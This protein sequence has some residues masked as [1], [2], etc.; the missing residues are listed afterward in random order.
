MALLL[1]AWL[2][3]ACG[4]SKPAYC[5]KASELSASVKALTEVNLSKEGVA[6]AEAAIKR[7]QDSATALVDAAKSEFP[8][9]TEAISTAASELAASVKAAANQATR[10]TAVSQ[11]PA[12]VAALG[13]AANK[14][15]S[16]TKSKCE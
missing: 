4:A 9:Q 3:S 12:E 7:V 2:I 10:S 13:L 11:I 1:C 14:F 5:T 15:I 16:D 8:Q 6:G